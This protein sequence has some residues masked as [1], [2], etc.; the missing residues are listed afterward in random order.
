MSLPS[1]WKLSELN[2]DCSN[3]QN[4]TIQYRSSIHPQTNCRDFFFI[5][6][7]YSMI[8]RKTS[9]VVIERRIADSR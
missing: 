2:V 8:Y 4:I 1:C 3:K 7:R 9:Y 6:G 5:R